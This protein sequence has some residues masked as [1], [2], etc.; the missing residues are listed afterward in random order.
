[1]IRHRRKCEGSFSHN[2]QFCGKQFHRR[3]LYVDHL[4]SNHNVVDVPR[5]RQQQQQPWAVGDDVSLASRHDVEDVT[6]QR[7][8]PV[9]GVDEGGLVDLSAEQVAGLSG[10]IA[11]QALGSS[12]RTAEQ[13]DT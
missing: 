8:P 6:R 13:E 9:L 10:L 4:S 3:D 7:Q 1:M 11:S 5:H 12:S 2:C